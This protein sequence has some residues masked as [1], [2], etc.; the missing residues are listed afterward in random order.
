ME[1][2]EIEKLDPLTG[3]WVPCGKS[4]KPEFQVQG[5]QEGKQYKFRVRAVNKEGGSDELECDKPIIA[6]NPFDEPGKPGRP[7][8]TDWDKDFVDLEWAAPKD[9][10]GKENCIPLLHPTTRLLLVHDKEVW[11]I[12]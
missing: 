8:P 9:D 1:G 4:D 3:T 5:L 10:G 6:K 7:T 12:G 11:D 2:Y